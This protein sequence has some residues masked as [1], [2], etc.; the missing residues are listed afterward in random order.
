MPD[1]VITE[2]GV[3]D[4]TNAEYHADPVR[5]GSLS[6][7][8]ARRLLDAPAKFL[9]YIRGEEE[10]PDS[11]SLDL[12]KVAHAKVLGVGQPVMVSDVDGRT[13]E[14][15]RIREEAEA[16]GAILVKSETAEKVDAMAEALLAHPTARPLLEA[17]SGWTEQTL[18]WRD[19][20]VDV[21]RRAMLDFLPHWATA[22]GEFIVP[23]YKT[24]RSARPSNVPK[25]IAEH[26]YHI[27]GE[28][29]LDG[30]RALGLAG[31]AIPVFV[32]IFQEKVPPYLVTVVTPDAEMTK[33]AR[34]QVEHAVRL[35][36][37]CRRTDRYPGYGE[38]IQPVSLP[39]Y[40]VFQL[41]EQ[42]MSGVFDPPARS[43]K[44][45]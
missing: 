4:L 44:A 14:G 26:G 31:D 5:G 29:Y 16:A 18:V 21:M 28:F 45:S 7:T 32:L 43:R 3:Y 40:A 36:A 1:V 11:P 42:A 39:R 25:A 24:A 13:K 10:R 35:Y 27:Q 38:G 9:T 30:I 37:E 12:G 19:R 15:K 20:N 2:P 22:R 6:S 41:E 33:W 23:D 34:T 17:E 8:G